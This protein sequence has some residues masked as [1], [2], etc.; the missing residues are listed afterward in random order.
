MAVVKHKV[1]LVMVTM[2]M[3]A[4]LYPNTSYA[5]LNGVDEH[6]VLHRVEI[7][8]TGIKLLKSY[9]DKGAVQ[10]LAIITSVAQKEHDKQFVNNVVLRT[11]TLGGFFEGMKNANAKDI[12]KKLKETTID[13]QLI[14]IDDDAPDEFPKAKNSW[15]NLIYNHTQC[16]NATGFQVRIYALELDTSANWGQIKNVLDEISKK[17]VVGKEA[18]AAS[19]IINITDVFIG[20]DQAEIPDTYI[21]DDFNPSDII[22]KSSWPDP[23]RADFT[24]TGSSGILEFKGYIKITHV[25][26]VVEEENK[27]ECIG[28]DDPNGDPTGKN[29]IDS[30]SIIIDNQTWIDLANATLAQLATNIDITIGTYAKIDPPDNMTNYMYRYAVYID[31][32]ANSSTGMPINSIGADYATFLDYENPMNEGDRE[33]STVL[34][35]NKFEDGQWQL[36]NNLMPNF[37]SNNTAININMPLD[38]IGLDRKSFNT[39]R[40]VITAEDNFEFDI[41]P[42]L[43]YLEI[44]TTPIYGEAI[45]DI[46]NEIIY[47][48]SIL[49]LP[50]VVG[51]PMNGLPVGN[52]L[53]SDWAAAGF[54]TKSSDID[55]GYDTDKALMDH[56]NGRP[57]I[58]KPIIAVGGPFVNIATSYYE[59]NGLSLVRVNNNSTHIWFED[60]NGIVDASILNFNQLETEDVFVIQH[61]KD[62]EKS[63]LITYGFS[64]RGT[65]AAGLYFNDVIWP[66]ISSFDSAYYIIKWSDD[67]DANIEGIL[68]DNYFILKEGPIL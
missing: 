20:G 8:L 56:S 13:A 66:N 10:E 22:K 17:A 25:K 28:E 59:S 50:N 9:D 36:I 24:L 31:T 16:A 29:D 43:G 41:M 55:I 2:I 67:G 4:A 30:T 44:F 3:L 64:Y 15:N 6:K 40:V 39:I 34:S 57:K 62:G 60:T 46:D 47:E 53:F 38:S 1:A 51:K 19:A 12:E 52:A 63:V 49:I 54:L 14:V 58:D 26:D 11:G 21:N 23:G 45:S 42:D 48:D 32:D 37:V 33:E 35:L 18:L 68:E 65:F 27:K 7:Y 5:H 61:F